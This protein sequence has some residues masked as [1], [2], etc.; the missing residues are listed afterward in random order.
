MTMHYINPHLPYHTY[1]PA[2]NN[3][4]SETYF[5]INNFFSHSNPLPSKKPILAVST[6]SVSVVKASEKSTEK[7]SYHSYH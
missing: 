5:S 2:D 6:S 1:R 4:V 3:V 7:V